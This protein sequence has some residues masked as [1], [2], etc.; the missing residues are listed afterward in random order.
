MIEGEV[1]S[2]STT[3]TSGRRDGEAVLMPLSGFAGVMRD[4]SCLLR[5]RTPTA[6]QANDE[7]HDGYHQQQ[8]DKRPDWVRADDSQQPGDEQ[9]DRDCVQHSDSSYHAAYGIG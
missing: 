4:V 1:K 3:K 8:M 5:E 9:K 6:E 2:S 7:Q